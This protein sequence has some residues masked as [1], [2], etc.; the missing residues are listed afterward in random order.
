MVD[1]HHLLV[2]GQGEM[3]MPLWPPQDCRRLRPKGGAPRAAAQWLAPSLVVDAASRPTL[4]SGKARAPPS[5][6]HPHPV[7]SGPTRAAV[8]R[9]ALA[10][11]APPSPWGLSLGQAVIA[12]LRSLSRGLLHTPWLECACSWSAPTDPRGRPASMVPAGSQ[13][14]LVAPHFPRHTHQSAGG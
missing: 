7:H 6:H 3:H 13:G 5:A 8:C 11:A 10:S 1:K 2:S 14:W 4:S 9:L 12:A